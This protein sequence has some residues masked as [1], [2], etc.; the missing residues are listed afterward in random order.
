MATAALAQA[1]DPA[2]LVIETLIEDAQFTISD[3]LYYKDASLAADKSTQGEDK[4]REL[5][6]GP[7]QSLSLPL[8]VRSP[9]ALADRARPP[10][11]RLT[12]ALLRPC[13]P[14]AAFDHLDP[15]VQENF[16]LFVEAR[17]F[18]EGLAEQIIEL[19]RGKEVKVRAHPVPVLASLRS[20]F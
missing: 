8:V 10:D 3:V 19:Q 17:G 2:A 13:P 7:G 15:T 6:D 4:R 5:Y 12:L 16:Q 1:D 18:D 14:S 9:C 20:V 11:S